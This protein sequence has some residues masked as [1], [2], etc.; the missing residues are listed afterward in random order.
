MHHSKYRDAGKQAKTL[1]TMSQVEQGLTRMLDLVV[2]SQGIR[3][4]G[5]CPACHWILIMVF[6]EVD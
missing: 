2:Y 1:N 4:W 3:D 5:H 6:K